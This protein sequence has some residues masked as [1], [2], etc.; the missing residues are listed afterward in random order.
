MFEIFCI[1]SHRITFSLVIFESHCEYLGVGPIIPCSIV[2]GLFCEHIHL[3][4]S[5]FGTG[6]FVLKI[7]FMSPLQI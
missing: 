3:I 7:T 2:L 4:S 1:L 5:H 6:S